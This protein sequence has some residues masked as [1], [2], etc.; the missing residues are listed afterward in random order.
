MHTKSILFKIARSQFAAYFIGF[1]FAHLT[2]LMPL[3]RL[4]EN[5]RVIIFKHPVPSWQT[6]WLG[7]P[8]KRLRSFALL[9]FEDTDTQEL[10]LAVYE[11][12]VKTAVSHNLASFSILV[13][14]GSYQD[15]PQIHF[16]LISGPTTSGQQW[17]PEQYT[18]P[19]ANTKITRNQQ[20]IAYPHPTPAS[21]FHFMITPE[22]SI[23]SLPKIDFSQCAAQGE[24]TAVL[25]LAQHLITQHTSPAYRL[26][27]NTC[28]DKTT[29]LTFHL[30]T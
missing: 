20:A 8:K 2:R 19:T 29:P 27:I 16:H 12:L 22:H 7:V 6:H 9:N 1:A 25:H 23:N 18:P 4:W 13:N 14:G 26:Q 15:V 10:I 21:D 11:G 28:P 3:E 17:K 24:I 5:E 30:I